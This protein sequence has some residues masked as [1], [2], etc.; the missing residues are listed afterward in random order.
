MSNR[1][2]V[3]RFWNSPKGKYK[4]WETIADCLKDIIQRPGTP[5][6]TYI[7]DMQ[8]GSRYYE[9]AAFAGLDTNVGAHWGEA[10]A[11]VPY[12]AN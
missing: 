12:W 7:I 11:K 4:M 10:D 5:N 2:I 3:P 8:D 6:K 1:G 9:P